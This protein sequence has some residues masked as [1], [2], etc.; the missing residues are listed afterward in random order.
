MKRDSETI[1]FYRKRLPHWEVTGGLYFV[2]IRQSGTIPQRGIEKLQALKASLSNNANAAS[3][4][5]QRKI[6]LMLETLLD[7]NDSGNLC[8][9]PYF[10]TIKDAIE[11]RH[12]A[13]K[14]H[15]IEYV[16]MPNHVHMFFKSHSR[17]LVTLLKDFKRWTTTKFAQIDDFNNVKWQ[18]E[19][20]DHWSRT[21][22]EDNKIIKYIRNNPQKANLV[23]DYK[24]WAY[25][26][27]TPEK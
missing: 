4:E 7:G 26:S 2:T 9:Q 12:K 17:D 25:G 20:F 15:M 8:E 13:K 5:R 21:P 24:K 18:R 16:V 14:W 19:W 11:Y 1:R 22:E 3:I 6:F 10:E 27:W 23:T